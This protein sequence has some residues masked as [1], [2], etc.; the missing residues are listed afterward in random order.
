MSADLAHGGTKMTGQ[1]LVHASRIAV[2]GGALV[3]A[4][5]PALAQD[6][7][8][9]TSTSTRTTTSGTTIAPAPAPAPAPSFIIPGG[10]NIEAT[11]LWMKATKLICEVQTDDGSPNDEAYAII[12]SVA[13]NWDRLWESKVRV[14]S[15]RIY[16]DMNGGDFRALSL[17]V[18]GPPD[19]D[20]MAVRSPKDA[21]IMVDV[22]EHDNANVFIATQ[23][24]LANLI[25]KVGT[26]HPG[27][28]Y[29]D[30]SSMLYETF[31]HSMTQ[32]LQSDNAGGDDDLT[33]PQIVKLYAEDLDAARSGTVVK[34]AL[35]FFDTQGGG[36][37]GKYV[38][39]LQLG[40]QGV[41]SVPW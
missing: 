23:V 1:S 16:E 6:T 13:L 37:R 28:S 8:T 19:G 4:F 24:V 10:S 15:T 18:W 29:A 40:K 32:T 7:R 9:T 31:Y 35:T 5:T 20:A 25:A 2:A 33:H 14:A 41:S 38:L 34:K 12:A 22:W 17:P 27:Y 39:R 3:I 21:L 11:P 36:D 26:L 30:V